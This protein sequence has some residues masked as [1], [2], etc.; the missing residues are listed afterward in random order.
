MSIGCSLPFR[1]AAWLRSMHPIEG[2]QVSLLRQAQ[3]RRGLLWSGAPLSMLPL[4]A[5]C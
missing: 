5:S 4:L 1:L 3:S 2:R